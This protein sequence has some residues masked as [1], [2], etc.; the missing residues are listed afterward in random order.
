LGDF[1]GL[2]DGTGAEKERTTVTEY[3]HRPVHVCFTVV[4]VFIVINCHEAA[5]LVLGLKVGRWLVASPKP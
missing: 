5:S 4:G 1:I 3:M 2:L